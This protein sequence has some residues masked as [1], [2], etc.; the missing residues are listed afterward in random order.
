MALTRGQ[1]L[2]NPEI[3]SG[4]A[5][6]GASLIFY[7]GSTN[8]TNTVSLKAPDSLAANYTLTLPADDG[9]ANQ[10]LQTNGTGVLSWVDAPGASA[11]GSDTQIQ[12]N[13]SGSFAGATGITTDGSNLLIDSQGD[14]RLGDGTNYIAL[15]SPASIGAVR[16]YTL[17][18]TIGSAGDILQI[19]SSPT[20]TATDATLVWANAS[21]TT[22][23][24]AGG[25]GDI[26][27]SD[28]AGNFTSDTDIN[29]DATNTRLNIGN[30][31]DAS[32]NLFVEGTVFTPVAIKISESGA[33]RGPITNLIRE[34]ISPAADD[35]MA[36]IDW[37]G[38]YDAGPPSG[39]QQGYGYTTIISQIEDPDEDGTSTGSI[40]PTSSFSVYLSNKDAGNLGIVSR[41]FYS[42]SNGSS[43]VANWPVASVNYTGF[44]IQCTNDSGGSTSNV[45]VGADS[46][47]L[48]CTYQGTSVFQISPDGVAIGQGI[49]L[50]DDDRTNTVLIQ[51]PAN[52]TND[53]IITLPAAGG[54]A[55]DILQFDGSQNAS[56]VSNTRT[57]NFVIDGGGSAITTGKKG[58]IV[59]DGDYTVTGWTI[60]A[61]QSGSIVVDVN[62]S[63]FTGFPTTSSIA[64]TELPTLSSAQKAE[65]L[66]LSS[67]T[68]TLSAR[69]VI[70]FEVDSA[71]TVT[72]VTVALRL[73]PS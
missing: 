14:L 54:A 28:G 35:F 1:I 31:T 15:Q 8:G 4:V 58:V 48:S 11:A 9:T 20:P 24:A 68:T 30:K 49:S 64:G 19:A 45:S 12:Y 50:Q 47:L 10:Y 41:S 57:L 61:D 65:D 71:T 13:S 42:T 63:T 44:T 6:D 37:L 7:E 67:W 59:I 60:I 2:I 18:A 16:T 53:Y 70:E 40:G 33:N 36:S 62:R 52:V 26:Q 27:F 29:F 32:G 21:G 56:F 34:S 22:Q 17:P 51:A 66:T 25:S 5:A 23:S 46:R 3:I 39:V 55:N 73:V 43:V 38:A 69:D 72:R